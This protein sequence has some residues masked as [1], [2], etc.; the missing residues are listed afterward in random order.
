MEYD[1]VV[2]ELVGFCQSEQQWRYRLKWLST[3]W[4][5]QLDE[6]ERR[7]VQFARLYAK[8]FSHCAIGDGKRLLLVAHLCNILDRKDQVNSVFWERE[9]EAEDESRD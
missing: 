6:D 7:L 5:K 3:G 2:R 8:C 4:F 1:V 9:E